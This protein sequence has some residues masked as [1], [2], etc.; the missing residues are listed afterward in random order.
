[1]LILKYF[2]VVGAVL[3]SLMFAWSAYLKPTRMPDRPA[4]QV[5]KTEEVF[6][7]TPAPPLTERP[8]LAEQNAVAAPTPA[9]AEREPSTVQ[10]QPVKTARA[11]PRKPKR[12]IARPR[13]APDNSYAYAPVQPFLFGWR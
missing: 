13:N 1:M 9:M 3:S 8:P 7:P 2:L 12:T 4:A 11:H 10:P 6:R 5:A